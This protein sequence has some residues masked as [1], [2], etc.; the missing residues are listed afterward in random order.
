MFNSF[1]PFVK[2]QTQ[3][4][5]F[6]NC[7][8]V[9]KKQTSAIRKLGNFGFCTTEC[10]GDMKMEGLGM[11]CLEKPAVIKQTVFAFY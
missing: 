10:A 7:Y 2:F 1:E 3:V 6:L 8:T 5:I 4:I 9:S 11:T